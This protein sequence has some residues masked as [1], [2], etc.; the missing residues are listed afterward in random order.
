MATFESTAIVLAILVSTFPAFTSSMSSRISPRIF[1]DWV[2]GLDF[3]A[4]DA[5]RF[6]SSARVGSCLWQKSSP[7]L[8]YAH[9]CSPP[10]LSRGRK[11]SPY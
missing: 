4:R 9:R 8:A 7:S 5:F 3:P 1:A 10:A 2:S 11:P 6:R